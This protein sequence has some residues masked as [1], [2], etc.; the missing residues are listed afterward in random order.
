MFC[1][2]KHM[3]VVTKMILAAAPAN[4]RDEVLKVLIIISNVIFGLR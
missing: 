4:D 2:D 3:F 1:H